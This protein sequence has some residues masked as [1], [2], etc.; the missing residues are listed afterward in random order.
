MVPGL[1]NFSYEERREAMDLPSLAYRRLRGDAMEVYKYLKGIYKVDS[2]R[3]LPLTGP[4][5]RRLKQEDIV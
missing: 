1:A 2:S 5:V 4:T 3:M